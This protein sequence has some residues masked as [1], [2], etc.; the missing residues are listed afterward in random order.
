LRFLLIFILLISFLKTSEAS[1]G[2]L[3][4]ASWTD[5]YIEINEA[6]RQA[7][8]RKAIPAFGIT[9]GKMFGSKK[10]GK[11]MEFGVFHFQRRFHH[12]SRFSLERE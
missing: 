7:S 1:V 6:K 3:T 2:I 11:E 9:F 4:G 8:E 12:D 5:P 10:K